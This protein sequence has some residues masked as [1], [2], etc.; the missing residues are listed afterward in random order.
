MRKVLLNIKQRTMKIHPT[1]RQG[2]CCFLICWVQKHHDKNKLGTSL[3]AW[4]TGKGLFPLCI[5]KIKDGCTFNPLSFQGYSLFLLSL[6][7]NLPVTALI[8]EL[9][10]S[11]AM[12]VPG[13]SFRTVS[14]FCLDHLEPWGHESDEE[15]QAGHIER[16]WRER[17]LTSPQ[18]LCE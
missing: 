1:W 17:C 18:L 7:L 13:L 11:D 8:L 4:I 9:S 3:T 2:C 12:S 14:S 16:W 10:K 6:A 5:W 15:A